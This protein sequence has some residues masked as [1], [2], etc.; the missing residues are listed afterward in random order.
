MLASLPL[1]E[2]NNGGGNNRM[3][4]F[5]VHILGCGSALPT[6]K[7][8]PTSQM[9]EFREHLYMVDCGEGAQ[10]QFRH[11]RIHFAKL[12]AIFISHLH[13]DHCF[14]LLGLISTLG[15]LGRTAPLDVF[16]PESFGRLFKE[17]LDFFCDRIEYEVRF[18]PVDTTRHESIFETRSLIVSTIPLE[19]RVP[20]CGYLFE[21]KPSLPHIRRDMIDYYGIP[22]SQINNIKNGM[23]WTTPE[24]D[25]I[26]H[27]RLVIPAAKPR[28]YAFCSDTRYMPGLHQMVS[29]VDM[30]YHE[31]TYTSAYESR[32]K[33]YY[34]S[35]A[36]QAALVAREAHVG[37]L[38][39]GH[40]SVRYNDEERLLEEAK[41]V[42]PQ[43]Y[44]SDEGKIFDV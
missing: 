13:G 7:H 8:N 2:A 39:L 42:F 1:S 30:L 28:K 41:A 15:M 17:M 33:L 44:L 18:H 3:E 20:C 43:S 27:C 9:V 21:G 38:V 6:L 16:A 22:V 11:M 37:K 14:G 31:S 25:V 23:D 35:T 24:G 29:G 19:H 12:R 10:L 26:P 4:P 36:R 40:Y 32:A 34:H 5:R